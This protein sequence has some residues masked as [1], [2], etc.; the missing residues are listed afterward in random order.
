M[1]L[2]R[3]ELPA[4]S[5]GL[6]VRQQT[7]LFWRARAAAKAAE[8]NQP[9]WRKV[10][11][12]PVQPDERWNFIARKRSSQAVAQGQSPAAAEA[13][14]QWFWLSFAPAYPLILA[15]VV[16][17]QVF[18]TARLLIQITARIV[19][20]MAVFF[21]DGFSCDTAALL[22]LYGQRPE[23]ERTGKRGRP[24]KKA[25]IAPQ[26]EL[27]YAQLIK[28][29]EK[30]RLKA[31]K[32]RVIFAAEKLL[33]VGLKSSPSLLERVNQTFRHALA[34]LVRQSRWFGKERA[35]MKKRVTFWTSYDN[36][37]RAQQSLR[38]AIPAEKRAQQGLIEQKYK[39]RTAGM[40]A[41]LTDPVWRFRELVTAK[42]APIHFQSISG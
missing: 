24:R 21:S 8:T 4:S 29:K 18:E 12:T 13:G 37:A 41:K 33:S 22:C 1:L 36:F 11:V 5:L 3:C 35:A 34:P 23:F 32:E 26:A 40:A 19:A 10:Q 16:G 42:F 6:G 25:I 38:W 14:R 2:G 31:L 28:E 20:G 17:P 30:G 15:A 39:Q 27:V 7:T 9:L